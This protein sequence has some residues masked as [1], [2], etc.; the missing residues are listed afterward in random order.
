VPK[1]LMDVLSGVVV[2]AVAL[3]DQRLQRRP[4]VSAPKAVAA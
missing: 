4:T 3:A 2:C 1:E